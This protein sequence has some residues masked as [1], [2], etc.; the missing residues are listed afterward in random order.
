[1][2]EK[3]PNKEKGSDSFAQEILS[4]EVLFELS[5]ALVGLLDEKL[6]CEEVASRLN[7]SMGY[8]FVAI[9]LIDENSKVRKLLS[10]A[11]FEDPV[12]IL[13]P[14]QG[15]SEQP[16]IDGKLNYTPDVSSH[17]K[18]FYGSGGSE[19]DVPIWVDGNVAGV[20][21]AESKKVNDFGKRDFNLLTTISQIT[22]LSLEKSRL[23]SRESK[24][25]E[26]LEALSYTMTELTA[27]QDLNELLE[28]IVIKAVSLINATGGQ[29]GIYDEE[30]QEI[31]I[32]VSHNL[33][34]NYVGTSHK[35]GEGLMG[36]VAL[37]KEPKILDNYMTWPGRL[38]SYDSI[39][40]TIAIPLL[41]GD[42]LLGVF[43]TITSDENRKFTFDDLSI[44]KMF[45]QQAAVAA[46][47]TR[48]YQKSEFEN[49]E[50]KRLFKEV[51]KQ[52]EYYEALLVNSPVAIATADLE[53]HIINWNPRAE[54]LFGYTSDEVIG[55]QL[56]PIVANH[57]DIVEEAEKYS[58]EVINV[59]QVFVT[60]KRTRRDGSLF[61]VELAALPIKVLGEVIGFI[62]IYHDISDLKN[63]ERELRTK[64]N[65]MSRQLHLAGEIQSSFL[66]KKLPEVK[67]WQFAT[68][69]KPALE[70]SGDFFDIRVLPNGKIIILIADVV[71]KGVGAALFMT[72]CWSLF[73]LTGI[74][75]VENPSQ[76]FS[77]INEYI[78][79]ETDSHQFVTVFYGVLNPETGDFVFCNAGHCPM[80]MLRDNELSDIR[81]FKTN[82]IPIGIEKSARWRDE[83]I[84]IHRG[85]MIFLYTDGIIEAENELGEP[86]GENNLVG[87][88]P[89]IGY[90]NAAETNKDIMKSLDQFVGDNSNLDDIALISIKRE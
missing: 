38:S 83:Q 82:G 8:D 87:S 50:R 29:L 77:E 27:L 56:N 30:R 86:F 36:Q 46:E 22:G 42:N 10:S 37:T 85:E 49:R 52:K 7:K 58:H 41:I 39:Y 53:G 12:P 84:I 66:P 5:S 11:G 24:R 60:T 80:Y 90:S 13:Y 55:K 88:F 9:F 75:N 79:N 33:S 35:L 70:T 72:L 89:K 23:F 47:G 25:I 48:L 16:F 43:T 69:V 57:P 1:M 19:V 73:R 64:N 76:L 14:G 51:L 67:G 4:S 59:G 3:S 61:D 21:I 34:S 32:I 40:A 15:V 45:A 2:R 26:T 20:I 78:L 62:A 74:E 54:K 68:T 17:E 63:I 18:Y 31:S 81:R 28:K 71:D 65:V 44:L 6:I